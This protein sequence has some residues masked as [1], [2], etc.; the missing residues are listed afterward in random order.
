MYKILYIILLLNVSLFSSKIDLT[1]QEQEYLN[2]KQVIKMCV[3]PDWE[4]FE[5]INK[6]G[7]HEGI[8]GDLI[9]LIQKR[10]DIKIILVPTKSWEESLEKSK[11]Y[12][13]DIMSFLN[14]TPKREEWLTFTEPIFKDPNVLVGRAENQY[15][16]DLSKIKASIALPYGTAMSELFALD[17]PNLTIIPT[18]TENEAFKLVEEKK[19]I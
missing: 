1:H 7:I 3:D 11:N 15:I 8:A 9:R 6:N 18:V 17:F 2:T 5:I 19:Q 10:L 4:P 12:E 14:Q 16:E 13:C